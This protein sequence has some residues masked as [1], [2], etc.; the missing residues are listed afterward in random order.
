[1]SPIP[2]A[3]EVP[4]PL[5]VPATSGSHGKGGAAARCPTTQGP[6]CYATAV[7]SRHCAV[8]SDWDMKWRI[9]GRVTTVDQYLH[10]P[11]HGQRRPQVNGVW[12]AYGVRKSSASGMSRSFRVEGAIRV[13]QRRSDRCFAWAIRPGQ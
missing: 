5:A 11:R 10:A 3:A 13:I 4:P 1:M 8:D 2:P 7:R 6:Q 12:D 9:G